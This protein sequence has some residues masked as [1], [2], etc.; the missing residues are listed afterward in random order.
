MIDQLLDRDTNEDSENQVLGD[1]IMETGKSK[2][3][4][5]FEISVLLYLLVDWFDVLICKGIFCVH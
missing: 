5:H 3:F 1:I 4:V 2:Y